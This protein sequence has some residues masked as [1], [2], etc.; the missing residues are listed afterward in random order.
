[1][2]ISILAAF[3]NNANTIAGCI[4]SVNAQTY[5]N[6]EHLIVDGAS[7]DNTLEIINITPNRVTKIIS[8]PDKGLY[9]AH[10]KDIRPATGD[11]VGFLHSDDMLAS[12]KNLKNLPE[13][14]NKLEDSS[15]GKITYFYKTKD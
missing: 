4:A 1:M 14:K 7:T 2:K 9:E 11:I 6:I 13:Q 5:S 12:P 15:S 8:E 3:F 10:T